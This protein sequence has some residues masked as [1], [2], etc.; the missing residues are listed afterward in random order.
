MIAALS[1][2]T[3]STTMRSRHDD[4]LRIARRTARTFD[5]ASYF[6]ASTPAQQPKMNSIIA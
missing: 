6:T 2:C 3:P 4:Y 1:I 5:T